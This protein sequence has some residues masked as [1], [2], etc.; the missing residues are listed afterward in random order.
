M[1]TTMPAMPKTE[2]R[3]TIR[4]IGQIM[5]VTRE[6]IGNLHLSNSAQFLH[7]AG[8]P[9]L[10]NKDDL[11]SNSRATTSNSFQIIRARLREG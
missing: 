3:A 2:N 4:I 8:N 11:P 1:A 7:H 5:I 6:D 10:I 9:L